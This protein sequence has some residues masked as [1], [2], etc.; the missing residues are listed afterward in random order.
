MTI[1]EQRYRALK[2]QGYQAWAG[3]GYPR[4]SRQLAVTLQS[5]QDNGILPTPGAACLELGCGNGAMASQWLA[6]KGYR[7]YGVDISPTAICWAQE[8]FAA[9][10]LAGTFQ[11]GDVCTLSMFGNQMFDLVFDGSCL[12]CLLGE[13]RQRCLNQVR[14]ILKPGGIFIVSSMCGEPK[15]AAKQ[16][17]YDRAHYQLW[18]DGRPWRTLMPLPLLLQEIASHQ[19]AVFNTQVNH[20]P[21]WDHATLCCTAGV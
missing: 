20:N 7:V 21:W 14:R 2:K 11:H 6:H 1:Y 15:L 10:S 12:H 19:F 8:A 3:E 16:Q 18:Q 13:Q 5:L 9:Q 4:A 17:D